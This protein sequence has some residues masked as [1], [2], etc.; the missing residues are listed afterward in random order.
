MSVPTRRVI[1]STRLGVIKCSIDLYLQNE[2]LSAILAALQVTIYPNPT[3]FQPFCLFFSYFK[4][5]EFLDG[6]RH[7]HTCNEMLL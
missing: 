7:L 4:S 6:F 5:T 3:H 1:G 2:P